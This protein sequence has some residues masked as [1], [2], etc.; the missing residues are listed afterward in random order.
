MLRYLKP[1]TSDLALCPTALA[2][3]PDAV[4]PTW[5]RGKISFPEPWEGWT[6]VQSPCQKLLFSATL[7]T[8]P[9][10]VAALELRNPEYYLIQT[11]VSSEQP[12]ALS[13]HQFAFPAGLSERMV[14]LPPALKPL[15]LLHLLH[16]PVFKIDSALCFAKSV[17]AAERLVNLV[18]F[19]EAAYIGSSKRFTART[20]SGELRNSE[21]QRLLNEFREGKIN[22]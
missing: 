20:Y 6:P 13:T 14:V 18:N 12:E 9:S 3:R 21:R 10:K 7:T 4:A 17:D 15:N 1:P 11:A 2:R 16:N 19:F 22:L 5:L 8:D